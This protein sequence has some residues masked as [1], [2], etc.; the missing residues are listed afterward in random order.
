VRSTA[1]ALLVL[2]VLLSLP[3]AAAAAGSSFTDDVPVRGGIAALSDVIPISP[4]PDRARFL[5]EAIRVVYSWPQAGPYSNEPTRQRI[6]NFLADAK[7]SD[8]HDDIPVPL[9]AAVW[10]QAVFH[11]TVRRE[12][13]AGAIL[14][15]RTAALMA[16]GL[17]GMDDETLQFVADH[18]SLLSRL[19]ERAPAIFGAFAESLHVHNGRVVVPGGDAAAAAWESVA[20]EKPDQPE[21]FLQRLFEADRGRLAYL[22]DALSHLDPATLGFTLR[23]TDALKRLAALAR[24]AFPEWEIMTAP[25]VRPASDLSAFF[26][27]LRLTARTGEDTTTFD[28]RSPTT[29]FWQKVFDDGGGEETRTDAVWIAEAILAHP[30]RERER[31]L[32]LFSFVQRAFGSVPR[33]DDLIPAARGFGMFPVLMLTLERMGIATPSVY[34]AA[35]QQADALTALDSGRG[36]IAVGQFQGALALVARLVTVRTIDISTAERLARELFALRLD[37]GGYY[38]GAIGAWLTDRVAPALPPPPSGATIDDVIVAGVAGPASAPGSAARVDWEGQRYLVDPGAAELARLRRT[39]DRQEGITF[40]TALGVAVLVRRLNAATPAVDDLRRGA[41][42]LDAAATELAVADRTADEPAIRSLR[43][44]SRTLTALTRQADLADARRV[45]GPLAPIADAL[46]SHALVSLAYACDL[47]DPDGTILIAGDPSRRHD[48]GYDL[49][50]R[51]ARLKAMWGIA[52]VETRHGPWHLVG[53]AFALDL[54]MAPLALRRIS[55]DRVPATPMLNLMQRDGFAATVAAMNSAALSDSDRDRISDFISDGRR[56][57]A[58]LAGGGE[59][60]D[61]LARAIDL[62]GWRTRALGWTLAHDAPGVASLFSLTE[63]L[64]LGGGSPPAFNS[65][66]TF[67]LRTAGCLCSRLAAPAEWRHWWGLSQVGLPAILVADLPLNAAVVLHNLKLPAVLAKP[68]L[69]AAMQD[70]VDATN[71][72]D[73]N[74]WLTL[75]RAAQAVDRARFEDYVAA[76]TADGPLV[77]E[78]ADGGK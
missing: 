38:D 24:R 7:S 43:E 6:A 5:A 64:V 77:A 40:A 34:A 35:A 51:D 11:K 12:D 39:R 73:G 50:G 65:W 70:F 20:G 10:S 61:A 22:F 23:G 17:A 42:T 29:G 56:R 26:G 33:P 49:P 60:V 53:S 55:N 14:A 36:A 32:E 47:G 52:A 44:A 9:T 57:V 66:G 27:R 62:D 28:I 78:S 37:A 15:D 71:P 76:A 75:A 19:A 13:L 16:Y 72:T 41:M 4:A 45:A 67:A 54:A 63:L 69:A 18:P 74:D 68:V 3:A 2:C 21:R 59:P 48:F 31:R 25:F 1:S 8:A 58:R 30:A 46:I